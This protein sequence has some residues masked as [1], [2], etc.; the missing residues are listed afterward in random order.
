[1]GLFNPRIFV[2]GKLSKKNI[3]NIFWTFDCYFR[4]F[5][6]INKYY[7]FN[8]SQTNQQFRKMVNLEVIQTESE[9]LDVKKDKKRKRKLHEPND[10]VYTTLT[11]VSLNPESKKE[12]KKKKKK[13]TNWGPQK[14]KKKKKK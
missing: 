9:S 3:K 11:D 13:K 1:M 5:K 2:S 4:T 8:R 12:K 7:I 14:K 10:D 6:T